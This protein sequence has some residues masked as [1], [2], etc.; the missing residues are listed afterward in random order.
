MTKGTINGEPPGSPHVGGHLSA[1]QSSLHFLSR[2][3]SIVVNNIICSSSC[4]LFLDDGGCLTDIVEHVHQAG[5]ERQHHVSV[6]T[7]AKSFIG[8]GCSPSPCSLD[9]LSSFLFFFR[10]RCQLWLSHHCI[11]P[12]QVPVFQPVNAPPQT[13]CDSL[14][15]KLMRSDWG[16]LRL[17]R[18][19]A[20]SDAAN[21]HNR[22]P[23]EPFPLHSSASAA[24]N[25]SAASRHTVLVFS[26]LCLIF[27]YTTL[28]LKC[29][30]VFSRSAHVSTS[31]HQVCVLPD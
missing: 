12:I 17:F 25:S 15:P 18:L 13:R 31:L 24:A 10:S 9:Y 30:L 1:V 22:S 4:G 11:F 2:V 16:S 29:V 20:P 8:Y 5:L 23:S 6:L 14:S 28:T 7:S 27:P 3:A 26:P 19:L 21:S